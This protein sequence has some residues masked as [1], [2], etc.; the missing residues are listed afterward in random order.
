[1]ASVPSR[2]SSR[3]SGAWPSAWSNS[4][5]PGRFAALAQPRPTNRGSL[6]LERGRLSHAL[7][8]AFL[9]RPPVPIA[10]RAPVCRRFGCHQPATDDLEQLCPSHRAPRSRQLHRT[11]PLC[12]LGWRPGCRASGHGRTALCA[13]STPRSISSRS[14]ENRS[15]TPWPSAR[16][17]PC[18]NGA[19]PKACTTT[20]GSGVERAVIN[21]GGYGLS[22]GDR[23]REW[24]Q[25][26]HK[27]FITYP[28]SA[29]RT[30]WR[31]DL[32]LLLSSTLHHLPRPIS[33][34]TIGVR[35]LPPEPDFW[36]KAPGHRLGA[37]ASNSNRPGAGHELPQVQD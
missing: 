28:D 7:T 33:T 16:P 31:R 30:S 17:A 3:R 12:Y 27:R 24:S 15:T 29:S 21:A 6:A 35:V 10:G 32:F 11:A 2:T 13:A 18:G 22:S 25:A 34:P 5:G 26:G 37:S 19:S 14:G 23:R 9:S 1:M 4:S 36:H 8:E 20:S